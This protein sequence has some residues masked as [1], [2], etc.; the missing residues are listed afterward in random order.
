MGMEADVYPQDLTGAITRQ[1]IVLLSEFSF[2]V[3]GYGDY[4]QS[5]H[6]WDM[7]HVQLSNRR[8]YEAFQIG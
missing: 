7:L 4:R 8:R 2:L 6:W 5:L 1:V 3:S